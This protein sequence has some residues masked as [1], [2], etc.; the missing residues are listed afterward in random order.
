MSTPQIHIPADLPGEARAMLE[1]V[2]EL[3]REITLEVAR[4]NADPELYSIEQRRDVVERCRLALDRS[5]S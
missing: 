5:H 4:L 2:N 3:L 1:A